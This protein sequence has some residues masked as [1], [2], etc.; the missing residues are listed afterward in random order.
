MG[1]FVITHK[2][3]GLVCRDYL[4]IRW[5]AMTS[6]QWSIEQANID[7][8]NQERLRVINNLDDHRPDAVEDLPGVAQELQKLDFKLN[9]ILEMLGQIMSVND[10][11]PV[12]SDVL[13]AADKM[14]W[15]HGST[16]SSILGEWVKVEVF[17]HPRYPFPIILVGKRVVSDD[18]EMNQQILLEP[19]SEQAQE[20]YEKYLFRCHR[21]QI[22]RERQKLKSTF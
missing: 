12:A 3:S 10:A 15:S 14:A 17:L 7:Q 11:P 8:L 1:V 22:A 21:R 18:P 4:P 20:L 6:E 2:K 13:L 16:D 9:L 5:R 19:L